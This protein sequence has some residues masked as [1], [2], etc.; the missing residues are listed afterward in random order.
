LSTEKSHE[1]TPSLLL[2]TE[3]KEEE[4][5]EAPSAYSK[6]INTLFSPM[7]R[8]FTSSYKHQRNESLFDRNQKKMFFLVIT[9]VFETIDNLFF[10]L[11]Q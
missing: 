11:R 6:I 1:Q 3:S 10:V 4:H 8:A 7:L 2:S 5:D 9:H